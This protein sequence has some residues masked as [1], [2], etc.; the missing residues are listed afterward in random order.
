M[1]LRGE[2]REEQGLLECALR[3]K[4]DPWKAPTVRVIVSKAVCLSLFNVGA[5]DGVRCARKKFRVSS[6]SCG[7]EG[8][9]RFIQTSSPLKSPHVSQSVAAVG[10]PQICSL[11]G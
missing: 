5:D 7:A 4:L 11:D 6:D 10:I 1:L 2:E 9:K 3:C 8:G